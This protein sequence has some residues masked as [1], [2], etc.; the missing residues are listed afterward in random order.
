MECVQ[1]INQIRFF[2]PLIALLIK[3][4]GSST[5]FLNSGSQPILFEPPYLGY[6][7]SW[8]HSYSVSWIWEAKFAYSGS[9]LGSS[10]FTLL[11]Q[12]PLKMMLS[13]KSLKRVKIGS[14]IF[15]SIH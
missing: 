2:A 8:R 9:I 10:Q 12:L 5:S 6:R 3:A 7:A 1:L 13:L 15:S 14:K 11:H 4:H